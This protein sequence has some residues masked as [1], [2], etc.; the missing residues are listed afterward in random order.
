MSGGKFKYSKELAQR[1]KERS[2]QNSGEYMINVSLQN[3]E[4]IS[5]LIFMLSHEVVQLSN[6]IP[7]KTKTK[8][9]YN[10]RL[11]QAQN[12]SY[13]PVKNLFEELF[14]TTNGH[15]EKYILTTQKKDYITLIPECEKL[16]E[17]PY[18]R[19]NLKIFCNKI[20]KYIKMLQVTGI[21][22][23]TAQYSERDG[24]NSLYTQ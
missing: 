19:M 15:C 5:R 13:L 17:I 20:K 7:E 3:N 9:R 2:G 14:L 1:S 6:T 11:S 21:F 4:T 23:I 8:N 16:L 24:Y 10:K 22:P 12:S 18:H